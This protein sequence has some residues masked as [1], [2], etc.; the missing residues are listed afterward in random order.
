MR[1][2][3]QLLRD[4][5]MKFREDKEIVNLRRQYLNLRNQILEKKYGNVDQVFVVALI[6]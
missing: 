5:A 1:R 4:N 6:L 2:R 3:T